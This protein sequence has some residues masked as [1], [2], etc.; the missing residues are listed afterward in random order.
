MVTGNRAG[1]AVPVHLPDFIKLPNARKFSPVRHAEILRI[2]KQ[3][4]DVETTLQG[5]HRSRDAPDRE[6][7]KLVASLGPR[8]W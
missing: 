3:G 4:H 1:L 2:F 6:V 8:C 5:F 7:D